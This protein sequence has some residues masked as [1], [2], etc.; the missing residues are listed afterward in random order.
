MTINSVCVGCGLNSEIQKASNGQ[1]GEIK[2]ICE[3][4]LEIML[5]S[6]LSVL[7]N[8]FNSSINLK[9]FQSKILLKNNLTQVQSG[10]L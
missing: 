4:K 10:T 5:Q 6:C 7:T 9:L 1:P 3:V 2:I 8:I